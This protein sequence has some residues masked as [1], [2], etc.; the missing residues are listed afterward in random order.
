M[1][2]T[3]I[4]TRTVYISQSSYTICFLGSSGKLLDENRSMS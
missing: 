1:C 4:G 2:R 3:H